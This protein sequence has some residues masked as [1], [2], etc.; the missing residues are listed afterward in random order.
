MSP[1]NSYSPVHAGAQGLGGNNNLG[2]VVVRHKRTGKKYVEKR[3]RPGGITHGHVQR[4]IRMMQACRNHPNIVAIIDYDLSY[5]R[6][7][8]GS[9]YMQRAE[10]GGLDILITQFRRRQRF[11]H[12]EGFAWKVLW[13]LA[14]G[15]AY[16]NAG[17]DAITVRQCALANRIVPKKHGWTSIYHRDLKPSNIFMTGFDPLGVDGNYYPT[18]LIGDFGCAL[19]DT[20]KPSS[21]NN[22]PVGDVDFSPP[23]TPQY[24]EVTDVFSLALVVVCLGWMKHAPPK[25]YDPLANNWASAGMYTVLSRCLQHKKRDR[26]T[27]AE[28]PKYVW[29]GYQIWLKGRRDCGVR[30]PA[31]ALPG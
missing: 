8:Y 4:E 27:P 15:V 14:I 13:E 18:I 1:R 29:H 16:M 24:S 7:N 26:P 28:L 6:L 2:I 25:D 21:M 31:W 19:S 5:S 20:D 22:T 9:L 23:E 17:Q 30:L 10:L 3:V 12:D 11:L